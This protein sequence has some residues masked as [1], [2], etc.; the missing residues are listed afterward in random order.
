MPSVIH[1]DPSGD[2]AGVTD[3]AAISAA[4]DPAD[5]Y[6]SVQ[7]GP[8]NWWVNGPISLYAGHELAGVKGGVNGHTA[9]A[10]RGTVINAAADFSGS[11]VIDINGNPSEVGNCR[12]RDL[13]I[14]C[15]LVTGDGIDG[16]SCHRD[17]EGL[18]V[19][20]VSIYQPT[21]HGIA[22]YQGGD[23]VDGDGLKL[24][25]VM[26]QR[27]G[28]NGVHRY[29]N[30]AT[31]EDVHVQYA[32]QAGNSASCHGF[33]SGV[34]TGGNA[35][36]TGCRSDLNVGS[37]WVID[38]KGT[39]G[40]ATKLVGC[41][42]ERNG[43]S[44]CLIIN[45]SA[46]GSDW[47]APVILSGCCFEGDG[48]GSGPGNIP[49]GPGGNYGGI[50]VQ[51]RNRVFMTGVITAVSKTDVSAGAPKY[52]LVMRR[53]GSANA[54]PETV[55]WGSGRLNYATSGAAVLGTADVLAIGPTVTTASG[56]QASGVL[57]T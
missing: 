40:D 20:D 26:I 10:P 50:E 38:H 53:A 8:G 37:G 31:I 34:A 29:V 28:L 9:A 32:G 47:R 54:R 49:A 27:P 15:D 17:V 45:S 41:S 25:G 21:G 24:R 33:Y 43:H 5:Q 22:F 55:E 56:F 44:G 39:Y 19:H 30:D 48:T 6:I 35:T 4:L 46:T 42:T 52:A 2:T 18:A 16:I 14:R 51:G 11:G 1:L 12:I 23:G 13:A 7:L 36:F 57:F 3:L